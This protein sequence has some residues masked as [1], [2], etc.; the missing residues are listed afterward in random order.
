MGDGVFIVV[1]LGDS[2][3]AGYRANDPYAI[4]R[5]TPYPTQLKTL[6]RE[7]LKGQTQAFVVNAGV[8]G[9]STDEMLWRFNQAVAAERPDAVVVWGGIND[10]GAAKDPKSIMSNLAELYSKCGRIG[11]V[12]VAC[13]LTPTQHTSPNMRQLN[14]MIRAYASV[15]VVALADLFPELADEDG[16]LRQEYSDDGV[17]LIQAGYRRVAKII[18]D[19]LIP[20]LAKM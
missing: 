2:L 10:L 20:I 7:K 5:R 12:P 4:D 3:T 8:N 15:K 18:L 6:L 1:A 9:D 13:T 17:H 14:S 11:A 19:S 16:N